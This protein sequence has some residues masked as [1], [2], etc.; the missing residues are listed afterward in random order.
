MTE[1]ISTLP[2][3]PLSTF[4]M[5]SDSPVTVLFL[6]SSTPFR[7][8]TLDLNL[9]TSSFNFHNRE[10]PESPFW[11]CDDSFSLSCTRSS[12]CFSSPPKFRCPLS[13]LPFD[14][15][16]FLSRS[17][18]SNRV[19]FDLLFM[20]WNGYDFFPQT[21]IVP[22]I[23][24]SF[25]RENLSLHIRYI[26]ELLIV[27]AQDLHSVKNTTIFSIIPNS[28]LWSLLVCLTF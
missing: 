4:A 18:H 27:L 1:V 5:S 22:F 23:I 21:S 17:H 2:K 3:R 13:V 28:K 15:L 10:L 14:L 24:E 7:Q 25:Y 12:F 26:P 20:T 19:S 11:I 8:V 16:S 9:L 6:T